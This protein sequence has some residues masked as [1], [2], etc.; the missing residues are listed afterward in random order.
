MSDSFYYDFMNMN[1]LLKKSLIT[2]D[3]PWINFRYLKDIINTRISMFT[4]KNLPEPL[5]PKILEMAL[6]FNNCLCFYNA[7]EL[8]GWVL[9]RYL[10]DSQFNMYY[11][12]TTVNLLCLNGKPLKSNVPYEDIILVL[13]NK[14]DIIP[15]TCVSE[16]MEKINE[17][18]EDMFKV[19]NICSLPLALVGDRKSAGQLNAIAKKLKINSPFIIGD[20]TIVDTIKGFNIDVPINPNDI[21]D[22]KNKYKNE[23]L[24]SLGI[25][26]VE[27]KRERIVTQELVNQNDYVDFVYQG[28]KIERQRFVDELNKRANLNVELIEVY[29]I[30]YNDSVKEKANAIAETT[31]AQVEAIKKVEPE[32][33]VNVNSVMSVKKDGK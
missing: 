31:T 22:L 20:D 18:E 7:T 4:Y 33:L 30:N 10:Y 23:C 25:Y 17:V 29:D 13:D 26:S 16:Y 32:A 1:D 15:F 5:T 24:A 27:Q 8:G 3:V 11:K 12:P 6:M 21:Y 19:L 28:A 14:M 9:C 2:K